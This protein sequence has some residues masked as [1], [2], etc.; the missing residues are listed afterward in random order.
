MDQEEDSERVDGRQRH[1][2]AMMILTESFGFPKRV[3]GTEQW[4][5]NL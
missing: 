5:T 1:V 2:M 4:N 3:S